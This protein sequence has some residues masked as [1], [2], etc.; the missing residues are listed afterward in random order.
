MA[1]K[2][3][4]KA[5]SLHPIDKTIVSS[6]GLPWFELAPE[7]AETILHGKP[8]SL[9]LNDK[10]LLTQDGPSSKIDSSKTT[11]SDFSAAVF[12]AGNII[13]IVQRAEGRWK[14]NCVIAS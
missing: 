11:V 13:A 1:E 10:P 8:L 2:E 7:E 6:L 12:S 3:G 4:W 14:Y 9:L 5:N